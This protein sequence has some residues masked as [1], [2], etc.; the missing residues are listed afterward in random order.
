MT[1]LEKAIIAILGATCIFLILLVNHLANEI[2]AAGGGRA[3]VVE[4]GKDIKSIVQE[5]AEE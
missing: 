2:E 1:L 3:V 4:M 5:I